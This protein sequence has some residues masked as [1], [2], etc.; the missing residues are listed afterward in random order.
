MSGFDA[1]FLEIT[2]RN[3]VSEFVENE[4]FRREKKKSYK[5]SLTGGFFAEYKSRPS[6]HCGLNCLRYCAVM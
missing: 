5:Q 2:L 1:A 4:G 6:L 3:M